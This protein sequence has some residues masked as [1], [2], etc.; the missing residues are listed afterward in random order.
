MGEGGEKRKEG[1]KRE[2]ERRGEEEKGKLGWLSRMFTCGCDFPPKFPPQSLQNNSIVQM[3]K[4]NV[5]IL[6]IVSI[7]MHPRPS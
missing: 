5:D 4:S 3:T 6:A 1:G 7:Y 2:E